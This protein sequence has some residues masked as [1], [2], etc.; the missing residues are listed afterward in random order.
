[1][2]RSK[3]G[4]DPSYPSYPIRRSRET[5]QYLGELETPMKAVLGDLG[6]LKQAQ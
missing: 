3:S 2:L 5:Q 4:P 1:L 6:M